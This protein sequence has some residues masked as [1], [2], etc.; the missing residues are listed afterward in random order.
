[1]RMSVNNQNLHFP[2]MNIIVHFFC[3]IKRNEPKKNQEKTNCSARFF[4]PRAHDRFEKRNLSIA[5]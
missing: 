5:M 2:S 1:M 3:L 4:L